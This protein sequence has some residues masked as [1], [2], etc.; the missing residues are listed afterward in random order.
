MRTRARVQGSGLVGLGGDVQ[1]A[2][3]AAVTPFADDGFVEDLGPERCRLVAGS[4]SWAALAA[5]IGRFDA[6]V[7][8]VRPPELARAFARLAERF[9]A[10]ADRDRP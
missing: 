9:A 10:A 1:A 2:P 8:A 4:W 3:A 5:A 6:D 7:E